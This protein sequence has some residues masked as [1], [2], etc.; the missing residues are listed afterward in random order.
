MDSLVVMGQSWEDRGMMPP[1]L[2]SRS[3]HSTVDIG[4][5]GRLVCL[6]SVCTVRVR[7]LEIGLLKSAGTFGPQFQSRK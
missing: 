2:L 4:D 6:H 3:F 5:L 7:F 1:L